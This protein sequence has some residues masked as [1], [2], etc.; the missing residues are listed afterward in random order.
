V[1]DATGPSPWVLKVK[2]GRAGAQPVKLG[3]RGEGAVEIREGLEAGDLVVVA[4]NSKVKAGQRLR[5][6]TNE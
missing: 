1:H 6:V 5:P 2:N 3:L 4:G